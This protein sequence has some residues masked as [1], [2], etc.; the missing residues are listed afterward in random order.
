[1]TGD[2]NDRQPDAPRA[3]L[4]Q[5]PAEVAVRALVLFVALWVAGWLFS[6][7][8]IVFVPTILAVFITTLL[9]PLAGWLHRHHMPASLATA[10]S[11]LIGLGLTAGAVYLLIPP[12]LAGID[13]LSANVQQAI[14][15]LRRFAEEQLGLTAPDVSALLDRLQREIQQRGAQVASGAISG[16][17]FVITALTGLVLTLVLAVYFVHDGSG[18]LRQML[19][20]TPVRYRENLRESTATAW[21]VLSRYIRGMAIVGVFDAVLIG[22]AL[23][24]LRVPLVIP[25]AVLTFVGAFLPLIG[26][27]LTGLLAALVAFVAKGWIAAVIVA[28]VALAVQQLEGNVIAPQVYGKVLELHPVLIILVITTGTV[29]AGILGAFIAVPVTAVFIALLRANGADSESES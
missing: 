27:F 5:R 28:G 6:Y 2:G 22:T 21:L 20:L 26:A 24:I 9:G 7:L 1:M 19:R 15:R 29:V 8:A 10:A 11:F 13:D 14:E 17:L 23:A 18:F 12:T 16:A 25:L 3:G 4:L